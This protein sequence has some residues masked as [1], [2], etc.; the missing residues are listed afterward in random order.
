MDEEEKDNGQQVNGAPDFTDSQE[1]FITLETIP[2]SQDVLLSGPNDEGGDI[3]FLSCYKWVKAIGYD[4]W[5]P[6][7]LHSEGSPEQSVN[8]SGDGARILPAHLHKAL[9]E[10]LFHPSTRCLGRPALFRL[11]W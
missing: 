11:P 2:S 9:I 8:P 7:Y 10:V 1:L 5:Q 3:I 4:F 6:H